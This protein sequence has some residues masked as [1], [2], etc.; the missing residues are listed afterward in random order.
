[1]TTLVPLLISLACTQTYGTGYCPAGQCV[2]SIPRNGPITCGAC[3]GGGGGTPGGVSGNLQTNNGSGGFGAFGGTTCTA[4]NFVQ[5]L[6]ASGAAT[7]A[8]PTNVTGSSAS[9]TGNAATA[10]ALST[11]G[12]S[13]QY[14]S[15]NNTWQ[16]PPGGGGGAPTTSKYL[17]QQADASLPNAQAMGALGT[18]ITLNTTTT[19]AQTIYGGTSCTNQFPRSLNASGTA[20]CAS[21]NLNL[22]TA[23]TPV[24]QSKGGLGSD[25]SGS[26]AGAMWYS[27]GGGAATYFAGG[28]AGTLLTNAT[29]NTPTWTAA[30]ANANQVLHGN[31][32]GAPTWSGVAVAD[33][34]ATGTPNNATYYRGDNTWSALPDAT[35]IVTGGIKLTGQLGG[36]AASPTVTGFTGTLPQTNGGTGAG[37]LTCTAGQ[38][39]TSNGTVQSCT[40]SITAN[41]L[42]ST[43]NFGILYGNGAGSYTTTAAGTSGYV[44][45]GQGPSSAPIWTAPGAPTFSGL[46]TGGIMW[47]NSTTTIASSAAGSSGRVLIS[48]GTGAP[49]FIASP[50]GTRMRL[51]ATTSSNPVWTNES[52]GYRLFANYT[53]STTTPATVVSWSVNAG[54]VGAFRCVLNAKNSATSN[55]IRYN[56]NGPGMTAFAA[57]FST[58]ATSATAEVLLIVSATSAAAQTA[59]IAASAITTNKIDV[60]EGTY[61]TSASG[62][63]A[64]QSS[65]SA[66]SLTTIYAGSSCEVF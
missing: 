6:S 42:S 29:A 66:A 38:A 60:I 48:G 19:G 36:T 16:T 40:S 57:K 41:N 56:V 24:P 13:G 11:A 62:T 17:L 31:A 3:S 5:Q 61:N 47:A 14:W 59:L 7:C 49:T 32:A 52:P 25:T 43:T 30:A 58:H 46:T 50:T 20:T 33:H 26:S 15:W 34:T 54:D 63:I 51:T 22:D 45:T 55:G 9:T 53:N 64:I 39:L 28:V 21:I 65:G 37:S 27:L 4:P 2:T 23:T 10:T 8:Q 12:S 18:G 35:S 1:M 44:L